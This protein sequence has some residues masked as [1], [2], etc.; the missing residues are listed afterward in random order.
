[1]DDSTRTSKLQKAVRH[2]QSG[3]LQTALNLYAEILKT[4]PANAN[5]WH[6]SGLAAHQTG[7]DAKAESLVRYAIELSPN[8]PEF[9]ANLASILVAQRRNTEAE[10]ICTDLLK[11][12]PD[13]AAAWSHLG[14]SLRQQRRYTDS[15]CAYRQAIQFKLDATSL[16]NLGAVLID[17]GRAVEAIEALTDA[18]ELSPELPQALLNLSAACKQLK[19]PETAMQVLLWAE[20]LLP[21]SY[22]VQV[23]KANLLLD[24]GQVHDAIVASQNAISRD[25]SRPSAVAGLG[26]SLQQ[27]GQW[28]EAL[29]AHQL[30]AELDP[31]DQRYQSSY[32][33]SVSLSPLLEM[34]EVVRR[35]ADWGRK[36]ESAT[37]KLPLPENARDVRPN[38]PLKIGYVSPDF[39][40]HAT[41][42]FLMPLLES[43][44]QTQF[45]FYCYSEVAAED[46]T[47][48]R[49]RKLSTG[50][51]RTYAVSDSELAQQIQQD[52]I[53]ILVDLAGHTGGNR[54]PVFAMKPA[55]VQISFL[56][57]PS[58]T[59]LSRIDYFLTDAIRVPAEDSG[60]FTETPI[61]LPHGAC[62]YGTSDTVNVSKLP[63][64]QNG[65]VTLGSTHR[66]EKISPATWQLWSKVMQSLPNAKLFMFRDVLKSKSLRT[67]ILGTA[68]ATGIDTNRIQ[69]G[70][71]MPLNYLEVYSKIDILLDVFPWGSGTIAHDAMWMG[72]PVPAIIGDRPVC[73]AT[74]SLLHNCGFPELAAR[75]TDDYLKIITELATAPQRLSKIREKLRPAMQSSVCDARRFAADIEQTFRSTWNAFLQNSKSARIV[76]RDI[77]VSR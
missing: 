5:A 13:H 42:R 77:E 4:D 10:V 19:D 73:R 41:V 6:L 67:Q 68:V 32:L 59:G 50:W 31:T 11:R 20:Q 60:I 33:Y 43:Q 75:D 34:P 38:R 12:F 49:I 26:R 24:M 46:A 65:F 37:C 7:D 62:C 66:L 71:E 61:R 2:H 69:F 15:L 29:E 53:D 51:R 76:S 16:C 44:D 36:I 39:R 48:A 58:T 52:Q 72:V 63:M 3:E 54:L 18:L 22:E 45:P 55:P 8:N 64:L 70:W 56:G 17:L 14:T 74:A 30:A 40:Q 35:H 27:T 25:P 23:N 9:H 28:E 1:M 57:Y 21:D 47:T